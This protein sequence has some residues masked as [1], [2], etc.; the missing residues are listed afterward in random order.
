[1]AQAFNLT[2]Q[3]NLQGPANIG[4][5]V[6]DLKKQIGTIEGDIKF[7]IDAST[8]K[9]VTQLNAA[10]QTFNSTLGNTTS[11]ANNAAN[12]LNNLKS[13][14]GGINLKNTASNINA[15]VTASQ[16]LGKATKQAAKDTAEARTELEEFGRQSALAVRRFAAFS[17]VSSVIFKVN[18]AVNQGVAAFIDY[19][20]QLFKL[21]Q[22]TG[23]SQKELGSLSDT[24]GNLATGLGVASSSLISIADTLAQAGLTA[25]DTEIALKALALTELAPSF[26]SLNETVEGSIALMR[27]FDISARDLQKALGSI[28]AV[29]ARFAV[30][31]S[32]L[33][34]AI[35]RTGG[36]FATASKGVSSGT[37]ALN[38]F[39]AVFTSVRATTR[40]SAETI[41]TGLRTI[42]TRIQREDTIQALEEYGVQ[43]TDVEGKFIGAFR[44]VEALSRGLSKIDPRSLEF[45]SIVEELGGFRQIGKVIPLIQQFATAQEALKVAQT[46]QDSLAYDAVVAQQSLAN[47]IAKVREQFLGLVRDIGQSQGFQFLVKGALSLTS[48]ILSVADAVK[49]VLPILAL[50]GLKKGLS[51]ATQ[52]GKGFIGGLKKVQDGEDENPTVAGSLGKAAGGALSGAKAAAYTKAASS[53]EDASDNIVSAADSLTSA[54]TGLENKI[55]ELNTYISSNIQ[56]LQ[57]NTASLG[58]NTTSLDN[59]T[60]AILNFNPG[61]GG[62]PAT[63]N[64]GGKVM[65]F[66]RGGVV[67]GTGNRD[68]V[69]AMLQPGEFVIRKKAVETIGSD[70]L[71]K[72]NKYASG[73][74]VK[75]IIGT[76][77]ISE[78]LKNSVVDTA[79]EPF[80]KGNAINSND[81]LKADI[82]YQIISD[83]QI[84]KDI[85]NKKVPKNIFTK[86][87]SANAK[88]KGMAFEDYLSDSGKTKLTKTRNKSEI[89]PVDFDGSGYGEAKNIQ[90][91][92]NEDLYID[93]LFRA[94]V[95]DGTY[96]NVNEKPSSAG[97]QNINLGK[98]TVFERGFAKGGMV[99]KFM[100]G[101]AVE[102]M[103]IEKA[104]TKSRKE[105]LDTLK[106]RPNGLIDTA[107]AVGVNASEI[108]PLLGVRNP[109]ASTKALQ[110]AIRKE[111]VKTY[112]R[113]TGAAKGL[114][115]RLQNRGLEFAAAG[116]FGKAF[117]PI[118]DVISSDKLSSSPTVRILSGV[119]DEKV[120]TKL[121]S[122]FMEG[123]KSL[124]AKGSEVVMIGDILKKFGLGR[125]LN[126]DFDRTLAEGADDILS[127][128]ATP[129][130]S[131]FG[132][133]GKVADALQKAKLTPLGS[134]LVDLVK[135]RSDLI[136]LMKVITARPQSTLDL[137]QSWLS[138]KGLPIPLSQFTGLGGPTVSA[139]QIAD[140]KASLLQP[141]SLFVDDDPRNI[142]SSL[143]RASEGIESYQ[144]GA[145]LVTPNINTEA[146]IQGGLLEWVIQNLGGPGATKGLGFDFPQGLK[147]AAKYFGIPDD[148]PTDV[149]RTISGPSTLNDNIV[150]YLKNVMGYANGGLVQKFLDG[151]WVERMQKQKKSTLKTD[152]EYLQSAMLF[153]GDTGAYVPTYNKPN[154]K[155]AV[156]SKELLERYNA[157]LQFVSGGKSK[158]KTLQPA[159]GYNEQELLDAITYYQGGSGPLARAMVNK[160][161][162]FT[163]RSEAYDTE[164]VVNR[165][166]AASQYTLPKRLY[167]GLGRGQFNEILS[168]VGIDPSNLI[169]NSKQILSSLKGQTI[170]FPTFLSTSINKG[171]AETFIGDP[172]AMLS[173][174]SSKS[175]TL[176]I[177]I[178]K[179]K[180]TKLS[181]AAASTSRRLPGLEKIKPEKLAGYDREEEFILPP[182][183]KFKILKA[184]GLVGKN[185]IKALAPKSSAKTN[186]IVSDVQE[187]SEEGLALMPLDYDAAFEEQ[188]AITGSTLTGVGKTKL[189][190]AVQAFNNGG[191][192]NDTV[193]ALLTPGEFVINK[194]AAQQIGYGKLNKL[195]QADK[196]QGYNKGGIVGGIQTFA[197]GGTALDL[198]ASYREQ[199]ASLQEQLGSATGGA[200]TL[201]QSKIKNL[202][203]EIDKAS[204][205]FDTLSKIIEASSAKVEERQANLDSAE[206]ALIQRLNKSKFSGVDFTALPDDIQAKIF[207][208]A[209]AGKYQVGG[210]DAFEAQNKA[211][212]QAQAKLDTATQVRDRA[213]TEKETKFSTAQSQ[214]DINRLSRTQKEQEAIA[215]MEARAAAEKRANQITNALSLGL[216][217]LDGIIKS[218]AQNMTGLNKVLANV[219]GGAS[220]RTGISLQV[221]K[222]LQSKEAIRAGNQLGQVTGINSILS[223]VGFGPLGSQL[224]YATKMLGGWATAIY[225]GLGVIK[226]FA[227]GLLESEKALTQSKI[228]QSTNRISYL[229]D[230][231]SK[232][233]DQAGAIAAINSELDLLASSLNRQVELNQKAEYM[234]TNILDW[235]GQSGALGADVSERANQRGM[236]LKEQGIGAYLSS[237]ISDL[238]FGSVREENYNKLIPKIVQQRAEEGRRFSE[239]YSKITESRLRQGEDIPSIMADLGTELQPTVK[240]RQLATQDVETQAE[241]ERV[242][243]GGG[244]QEYKQKRIAALEFE[245]ANALLAAQLRAQEAAIVAE[246]LN[247]IGKDFVTSIQRLMKGMEESIGKATFTL[248]ELSNQAKLSR[249]SLTGKAGAGAVNLKSINVIRN[250]GAYSPQERSE[251]FAAGGKAFGIDS[252]L[253]EGLLSIPNTLEDRM[254]SAINKTI[255]EDRNAGEKKIST[256]VEKAAID[257]IRSMNLGGD[258]ESLILKQTRSVFREIN[259]KGEDSISFRELAE[260]IPLL[261]KQIEAAEKTQQTA[262]KALELWQSVLNS[263]SE[264]M[265]RQVQDQID[266]NNLNRKAAD[267]RSKGEIA[268]S[269]AL[270]KEVTLRQRV[271]SSLAN[272]QSMTGGETNP[273]AI[274]ANILDLE[275]IRQQQQES[276]NAIANS[277]VGV[278]D[279]FKLMSDSLRSTNLALR[280]NYAALES[281]ANNSDI[282]SAALGQIQQISGKIKAGESFIEKLVTSSPEEI[283]KL[284]RSFGLLSNNLKGQ[285]NIGTTSEERSQTLQLFN[286]LGPL[287]GTGQKQNELRANVLQSMLKESGIAIDSNLASMID[288]IKNPERNTEM[289]EAI[290]IYRSG[291]QLQEAAN[292]ELGIIKETLKQNDLKIANEQLINGFSGALKD[293]ASKQLEDIRDNTRETADALKNNV[294]AVGKASGGIIYASAGQSIFKPKGTDTVPAMLTPGEFVVNRK[295]T[296]QN[297]PLLQSINN[298][299]ARGGKVSYY[300]DGGYII[301][302]GDIMGGGAGTRDYYKQ[303]FQ[304]APNIKSNLSDNKYPTKKYIDNMLSSIKD[305]YSIK[306]DTLVYGSSQ[307]NQLIANFDDVRK[308][309][310][311]QFANTKSKVG[312]L[313]DTTEKIRE[314]VQ[315]YIGAGNES[316][317]FQNRNIVYGPNSGIKEVIFPLYPNL[318]LDKNE[319]NAK[320]KS[321]VYERISKTDKPDRETYFSNILNK[322]NS[323]IGYVIEDRQEGRLLTKLDEYNNYRLSL[324]GTNPT[325]LEATY[326]KSKPTMGRIPDITL[327]GLTKNISQDKMIGLFSSRPEQN[328][329]SDDISIGFQQGSANIISGSQRRTPPSGNLVFDSAGGPLKLSKNNNPNETLDRNVNALDQIQKYIGLLGNETFSA[330]TETVGSQKDIFRKILGLYNDYVNYIDLSKADV[331]Q[332][333]FNQIIEAQGLTSK[334]IFPVRIYRNE[335]PYDSAKIQNLLNANYPGQEKFNKFIHTPGTNRL[336]GSKLF[337]Q[338]FDSDDKPIGNKPKPVGN[339]LP[340][341]NTTDLAGAI[342]NPNAIGVGQVAPIKDI[343]TTPYKDPDNLFE[344]GY[345]SI[346]GASSAYNQNTKSFTN[347]S[348]SKVYSDL[349]SGDKLTTIDYSMATNPNNPFYGMLRPLESLVI[350]EPI[351]QLAAR[352]TAAFSGDPLKPF[353][354]G[355]KVLTRDDENIIIG[356]NPGIDVE[357][358]KFGFYGKAADRAFDFSQEFIKN[359]NQRLASKQ[360][361]AAKKGAGSVSGD[362]ITK[363]I[364][365]SFNQAKRVSLGRIAYDL[366]N[367]QGL[368]F[369]TRPETIDDLE[370]IRGELNTRIGRINDE[371]NTESI[372]LEA[373][374]RL[375]TE[376]SGTAEK[377]LGRSY[378][379]AGSG[380]DLNSIGDAGSGWVAGKKIDDPALKGKQKTLYYDNA[381]AAASIGGVFNSLLQREINIL[382]AQR[383]GADAT[384]GDDVAE[385]A[386]GLLKGGMFF[387]MNKDVASGKGFTRQLD[388]QEP[389]LGTYGDIFKYALTPSNVFADNTARKQLIDELI[390][391]YQNATGKGGE[392]IFEQDYRDKVTENLKKLQ[393]WYSDQDSI[394]NT[395]I[396]LDNSISKY[397]ESIKTRDMKTEYD[398]AEKANKLLTSDTYGSLPQV[399]KS[400]QSLYSLLL[401]TKAKKAIAKANG[402]LIYASG[403]SLV[404]FQARGTDTVPA[405]LTPGEFVVNRASTQRNLPLL[406]AINKNK[407]GKVSYFQNGGVAGDIISEFDPKNSPVNSTLKKI[408]NTEIT[409][410]G[411]LQEILRVLKSIDQKTIPGAAGNATIRN[412]HRQNTQDMPDTTRTREPL[413]TTTT[414]APP[415]PAPLPMPRP[416]VNPEP[417]DFPEETGPVIIEPPDIPMPDIPIPDVP[418]WEPIPFPEPTGPE[419]PI[420]DVYEPEKMPELPSM[421]DLMAPIPEKPAKPLTF[422]YTKPFEQKVAVPDMPEPAIPSRNTRMQ[423]VE[424]GLGVMTPEQD[425]AYF[426]EEVRAKEDTARVRTQTV[427][428][429]TA[430]G[431]R[432]AND[433]IGPGGA[434]TNLGDLVGGETTSEQIQGGLGLAGNVA[435]IVANL[436]PEGSGRGTVAGKVGA[437]A[438]TLKGATTAVSAAMEGDY[439]RAVEGALGA[440]SG[441]SDLLPEEVLGP[442]GNALGLAKNTWKFGEALSQGEIDAQSGF[443]AVENAVGLAGQVG[444]FQQAAQGATRFLGP[445]GAALETGR[446]AVAGVMQAESNNPLE[447]ATAAFTGATTGDYELGGSSTVAALNKMGAGLQQGGIADIEA[448]YLESLLRETT[449]GFQTAGVP[450]AVGGLGLA[451]AGEAVKAG[452]ALYKDTSRS[453]REQAETDRML[454]RSKTEGKSQGDITYGLDVQESQYVRTI[455]ETTAE[456]ERL[457]KLQEEVGSDTAVGAGVGDLIKQTESRL[458]NQ[459]QGLT[460]LTTANVNAQTTTLFELGP[461]SPE[462]KARLDFLN[463]RIAQGVDKLGKSLSDE[464]DPEELPSLGDPLQAT[465]ASYPTDQITPLDPTADFLNEQDKYPVYQRN[466]GLI[467]ANNGALINFQP[468]GSDTVPAMLT[469]GEFV[470]NRDSTQ[471][472]L[473]LLRSINSGEFSHGGL[474]SYLKDGGL[475][476]P[477]Y[478]QSGARVG[479]NNAGMSFDISNYMNKIIGQIGS[480]ITEAV[481]QALGNGQNERGATGGVSTN[482]ES[483][484]NSIDQFVSRLDRIVNALKD[485]DIPP[486]IKIVGQ[487]DI[488]VVINGDTVLNQLKPELAQIAMDSIKKAFSQFKGNNPSWQ[489][490]FNFDI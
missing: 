365:A 161:F 71:H 348:I 251:A 223:K 16:S 189:D 424:F 386:R 459:Q 325:N 53:I 427:E 332:L 188:E 275:N 404:N 95:Q 52:F 470:V 202:E 465:L 249:E 426:N 291:V 66:A 366:A 415:I 168:D 272:V 36:V 219:I 83:D 395:G 479:P 435:D 336:G 304:T 64:K 102:A 430:I 17:V 87:N 392:F 472:H 394:L 31:S 15:V 126:L 237:A 361:T 270:G 108:Y 451:V 96:S 173:I 355:N 302:S 137:I 267:I 437:G 163:D 282:A 402:G 32:D 452:A 352:I 114:E 271:N 73:G 367:Q 359:Y 484:I 29:A 166:T 389:V 296:A 233:I 152:L 324:A 432:T 468:R 265:N 319:A 322:L 77:G 489:D 93:K 475:L 410:L 284:N 318:Y 241:I 138:E 234:W 337:L 222:N 343:V 420:P 72:M 443:A 340:N 228:E 167:S 333:K 86:L 458:G 139:G 371:T 146:A 455:A 153:A 408:D 62:P 413:P 235:L 24:I 453:S 422:D 115:T 357:S 374:R 65:G 486:E 74:T 45:A 58:I 320:I 254:S 264:A 376:I 78:Q 120:S 207:E 109:D 144:Y 147:G 177:D 243:S 35:Q 107:N 141:G 261:G 399:D 128:P 195:N 244:S 98:L 100:A 194:K 50:I 135:E 3:L 252:K 301:P 388:T 84:K 387:A 213:K 18:N 414:Q 446:G 176:G 21:Q 70:K 125:Q 482:I 215:A 199:K 121:E 391:Y 300:A 218:F 423:D 55:T 398:D 22:I 127:D 266:I 156:A 305:Y 447:L 145:N 485:I 56:A 105:I 358:S 129:K 28:N 384:L 154:E 203:K 57:N 369:A 477:N 259:Q 178:L 101:G 236:I 328:S 5:I 7:K 269:E 461:D 238:G 220:G 457:K 327:S 406:Q 9:G 487:H 182:N 326:D 201:I 198:I 313:S 210:K 312:T 151:G 471:K 257:S 192:V 116:M 362:L 309:S 103:T 159:A 298:G 396:D 162:I 405:M 393:S 370:Y 330:D 307:P 180:G 229:F 442:A 82:K 356:N 286:T 225:V 171:I 25:K 256:R 345:K 341:F 170:D 277:S 434:L 61:G 311:S 54:I 285:A 226:D 110:D 444:P 42:F 280:E 428:R 133:R 363:E 142:Q 368:N 255:A 206:E 175:K 360:Q 10:L 230:K 473:S 48:A 339:W 450:G 262:I 378:L 51:A 63:I 342:A 113:Q 289:Q 208:K 463:Q 431:L 403:G 407:G 4:K 165:L 38:E 279:N 239:P 155:E 438:D 150:T 338:L 474:V 292:Q 204:S 140:L 258:V 478:Y 2:A 81:I 331:E 488:N 8:I 448:E 417:G 445:A 183:T 310:D 364:D 212:A 187:T 89:Y 172:G 467:Y 122:I 281:L 27:Q 23:S 260:R 377:G 92:I 79:E 449:S 462:V 193:P 439:A 94:R 276:V 6:S 19:E 75:K 346:G 33:I 76:P 184:S 149:K 400:A 454:E 316:A 268:L 247:K 321:D 209:K 379:L 39:L 441:I 44:A 466:G 334:G 329:G 196:L 119:L 349:L 350:K 306:A 383:L 308:E 409:S 390:N 440:A 221:M 13:A 191:S 157:M 353:P 1:M 158:G 217:A 323:K 43:L 232:D 385:K 253:V 88:E 412:W 263:Y 303:L 278:T 67:P 481:K 91:S 416:P 293:Y 123:S 351:E 344:F 490:S 46:G 299:Y 464:I 41:A 456:L 200:K 197:T 112:N 273:A 240:A 295:A 460:Q 242:R 148:I 117:D 205:E 227:N 476:L 397:D 425:Q 99:Q 401:D 380:I 106:K 283:N 469:P 12:A 174:D 90:S 179:A 169:E 433:V 246:Q 181:E 354:I 104:A 130:F 143:K 480:G 375:F 26:D 136:P 60:Q 85:Q 231:M 294:P 214:D 124:A 190:L 224:A 382:R 40:E 347:E 418:D 37:D 14:V 411:V 372:R 49:G 250:A 373:W 483:G 274:S 288:A 317:S 69:P 436:A 30:E 134:E 160:D 20:R 132:D 315:P 248:Q 314:S 216:G 47:Q 287:L 80:R 164:D 421:S 11:V 211:I 335:I 111:Y 131:E 290:S 68:T 297:L 419:I 429:N 97:N 118:N 59:L 185:L 381:G 34:T 186:P 245:A